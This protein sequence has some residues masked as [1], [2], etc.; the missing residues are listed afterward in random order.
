MPVPWLKALGA[1]ASAALAAIGTGLAIAP[2]AAFSAFTAVL[3]AFP[4]KGAAWFAAAGTV[5][6][7]AWGKWR[8]H[9]CLKNTC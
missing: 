3:A 1:E 4:A 2:L 9:G 8:L 7:A 5:A 6:A